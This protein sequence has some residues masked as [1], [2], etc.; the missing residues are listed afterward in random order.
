MRRSALFADGFLRRYV[1]LTQPARYPSRPAISLTAIEETEESGAEQPRGHVRNGEWEEP[2]E[3][4][5]DE[6]GHAADEDEQPEQALQ[7][8]EPHR[9][10]HRVWDIADHQEAERGHH[11]A[12]HLMPRPI[13]D[14]SFGVQRRLTEPVV[15]R[16][17]DSRGGT[18]QPL[19][20]ALVTAGLLDVEA[21]E[22][23]H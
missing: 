13:L 10:H 7:R 14:G 15:R 16:E 1:G 18:R 11:D 22:P 12:E 23:Q 9:R 3:L 20:E 19:K 17:R 4:A 5:E 6:H 2:F 21:R 8:P